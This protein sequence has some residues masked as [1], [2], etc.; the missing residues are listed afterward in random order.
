MTNL[1]M[2]NW[3]AENLFEIKMEYFL[4]D[5]LRTYTSYLVYLQHY[6]QAKVYD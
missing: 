4:L 3:Y 5:S 1:L 6:S 2:T